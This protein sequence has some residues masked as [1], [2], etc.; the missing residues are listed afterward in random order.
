M[1]TSDGGMNKNACLLP[2]TVKYFFGE[3]YKH[4]TKA[5][6]QVYTQTNIK[7]LTDIKT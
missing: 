4:I 3:V 7:W 6:M 2:W 1:P 5:I